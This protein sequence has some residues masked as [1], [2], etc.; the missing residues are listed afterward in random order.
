MNAISRK[1]FNFTLIELL[2]VIAII[3]ILAAMLLPALKSAKGMAQR[4]TCANN[5]K[6][7]GLG[8][9]MYANDSNAWLP[10]YYEWYKVLIDNN[11]YLPGDI[12]PTAGASDAVITKDPNPAWC[13]TM[14]NYN[15]N[16]QMLGGLYTDWDQ[17]WG[18]FAKWGRPSYG[19]NAVHQVTGPSAAKN[20]Q[21]YWNGVRIT[22]IYYPT[23][24]FYAADC[25]SFG[26]YITGTST[27]R[28]WPTHANSANLLFG[29]MH[30]NSITENEIVTCDWWGVAYPYSVA[31]P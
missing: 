16:L 8:A 26:N 15:E 28:I 7:I 31:Y 13:P 25:N 9:T 20:N 24:R 27:H 4:I 21:D 18:C 22:K 14:I 6:Q 1:R 10:R 11:A 30:V 23:E 29:D 3:A 17:A 5:L 19:I 12:N 2:V